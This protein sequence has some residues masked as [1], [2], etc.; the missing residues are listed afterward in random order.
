MIMCPLKPFLLPKQFLKEGEIA[1]RYVRDYHTQ[2]GETK[3][4]IQGGRQ[5]FVTD[6]DIVGGYSPIIV[7]LVSPFSLS[8]MLA[9]CL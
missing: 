2:S 4:D 5:P 7:R 1:H 8:G 3:S 6:W 9:L